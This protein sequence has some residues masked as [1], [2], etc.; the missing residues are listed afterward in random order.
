[1][2]TIDQE[3]LDVAIEA[4]ATANADGSITVIATVSGS[5]VAALA[6]IGSSVTLT[7][8]EGSVVG[9][10][11]GIG[12]SQVAVTINAGMVGIFGSSVALNAMSSLGIAVV[13][14]KANA[15]IGLVGTSSTSGTML[16]KGYMSGS[17]EDRSSGLTAKDVWEYYQR[18]LT[19]GSSSYTLEQIADV[20]WTRAQRELTAASTSSLTQ[21]QNDKLMASAS[22]SDVF[23]A[24]ML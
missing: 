19:N 13:S 6:G 4:L 9:A 8:V 12:N 14:G 21:E 20:V 11:N 23:N 22:K 7:T 24:A 3:L 18:T 5:V 10:V 1:M 2:L 17:T 15:V 16:A